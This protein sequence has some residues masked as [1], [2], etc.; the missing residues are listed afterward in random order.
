MCVGGGKREDGGGGGK[1]EDVLCVW[2][3][4]D[5]K[6]GQTARKHLC[7]KYLKLIEFTDY[8]MVALSWTQETHACYLTQLTTL[9]ICMI[10]C[11]FVKE[12]K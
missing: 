11:N 12:D 1:M 3:G 8:P 9:H 6:V 7:L 2:G 4:G 10:C 5:C